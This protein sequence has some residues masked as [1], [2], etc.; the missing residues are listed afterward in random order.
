M[1]LINSTV[2]A[3]GWLF[4]ALFIFSL[5]AHGAM[6]F[7]FS[8]AFDGGVEMTVSG[9]PDEDFGNGRD[10]RIDFG[11]LFDN[12]FGPN[13]SNFVSDSAS[14][15]VNVDGFISN[16]TEVQLQTYESTDDIDL[17]TSPTPGFGSLTLIN[18]SATWNVGT[19][20]FADLTPGTYN[21]EQAGV[22]VSIVPEPTSL[23]LL[24]L[25]GLLI[26]RRRR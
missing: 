8:E 22:S 1:K 25:G 12:L 3:A 15:T 10:N 2:I 9:S 26:T 16:V 7:T 11:V 20:A 18:V 6:V 23:A 14:G 5:P 24:G 17:I 13:N 19:L 21:G 4:A